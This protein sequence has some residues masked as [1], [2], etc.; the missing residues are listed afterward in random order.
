MRLRWLA[1]Q[2]RVHVHRHPSELNV[3]SS[4]VFHVQTLQEFSSYTSLGQNQFSQYYSALPPSY[5]PAGLPS[6]DEHAGGLGVA[7]YSAVKS[8][9]AASAGLPPRGEAPEL[10]C[11]PPLG[12]D[13]GPCLRRRVPPRD[14]TGGGGA[15]R[16]RGSSHWRQRAGRRWT[17][18]LSGQS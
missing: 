6:A 1:A 5:V 4:P 3:C 18:E 10:A 16:C 13:P 11:A 14:P 7:E 17:Q 2:T 9:Q 8:E 12:T 15:P